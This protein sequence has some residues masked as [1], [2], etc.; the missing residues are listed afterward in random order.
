M[1]IVMKNFVSL[2]ITHLWYVYY[3]LDSCYCLEI[4]IFCCGSKEEIHSFILLSIDFFSLRFKTFDYVL[5]FKLKCLILS[6]NS[7][8]LM[9]QANL[10]FKLLESLTSSS[11][12]IV[13]RCGSSSSGVWTCYLYYQT[14]LLNHAIL[15]LSWWQPS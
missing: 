7:T 13:C 6:M 10:D 3:P 1:S 5:V 2:S 9:K 4:L 15:G 11:S 14:E 8:W 12:K